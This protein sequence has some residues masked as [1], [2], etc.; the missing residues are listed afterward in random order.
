ML[1]KFSKFFLYST[2]FFVVIMT[3]TTLF[4]Y[5]VGKYMWFRIA[6]DL[7]LISFLLGL[8]FDARAS[9]YLSRLRV[10]F[11]SPIVIAASA[12]TTAFVLAGFFGIDPA[13]SFWSNF[14]RGE[15]GLQIL[16]LY[17]FFVLLVTLFRERREWKRILWFSLIAALLM[18]GYGV[19]AGLKYI[20]AELTTGGDLTGKGGPWF[21]A[22]ANF[23][24]PGFQE[25]GYRFQGSIGNPAYVAA[26]LVFML[27]YTAYLFFD[28][29]KPF[30]SW[31]SWRLVALLGI[32]A[33]FFYLAATRGAFLGLIA[34]GLAF[35]GY[36]GFSIKKLRIWTITGAVVVV[37]A[38]ATL[39]NFREAP[40][41]KSLP[42]ARIFDISF[43]TRTFGDRTTMW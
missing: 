26:Y 16:H 19:G 34:G 11:H 5:I 25:S 6:V 41:I 18:I 3:P 31:R 13:F 42:G 33:I 15:G 28:E 40:F 20:D 24:G 4:P 7:A 36:T 43:S 14:E 12:F 39:I 8:I 29:S 27:F 22:F 23:I 30:H 17:V 38:A 2:V 1:F 9:V 32:F 35:L 10:A 37:I 21:Q